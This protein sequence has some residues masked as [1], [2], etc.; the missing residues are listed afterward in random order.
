MAQAEFTPLPS[1]VAQIANLCGQRQTGTVMLVSDD[2]R[3]GQIH[4]RAGEIVFVMCRGR[5]GRDALG[6]MRTMH[7]ARLSFVAGA[8]DAAEAIEWASKTVLDYLNGL[9]P[10]LPGQGDAAPGAPPGVAGTAA[11]AT[12][13]VAAVAAA[14]PPQP[15]TAVAVTPAT[16]AMFE[17]VMLT[18]IGPMAQIVCGDHFATATDAR[19][20]TVALATEIPGAANQARFKAEIAKLLN[21]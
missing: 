4:L 1:L 7:A 5:R 18:Y 12:K 13:P 3:M 10:D 2:N 9:L 11:V 8:I 19:A 15:V 20:L 14:A 16:K 17:K 21:L 6:I